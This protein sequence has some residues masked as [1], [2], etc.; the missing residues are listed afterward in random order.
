MTPASGGV[1]QAVTADDSPDQLYDL[2]PC[3]FLT[4]APDGTIIKANA[5][6]LE[7]VGCCA[8][9][10]VGCKRFPELLTRGG[11]IYYETHYAPLLAMHGHVREI[12]LELTRPNAAALPV[13]INAVL[14]RD[15]EGKPTVLRAVVFDASQRRQYERE[16]LEQS[17]RL[18][19]S[20]ARARSLAQT[21]QQTL[22]PPLPPSIPGLDVGACYRP[23]GD[24]TEVGGDFY[25]I[26]QTSDESWVV[27]LGDVCGKGVEAAIL[28]AL[29]RYTLRAAAMQGTRPSD[30]LVVLNEVLHKHESERFATAVCVRLHDEG[31]RWLTK[32][33]HGGHPLILHRASDGTVTTVGSPGDVLG[34]FPGV[35][36]VDQTL[37]LG[38]GEALL[39]YTDGVP[40]A[41]AGS[42]LY[43]EARISEI[44]A[45]PFMTAQE[46]IDE[47]LADVLD[48]QGGLTSDDVACVLIHRPA[49]S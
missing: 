13:L 40:E 23:A 36:I 21:L 24:G 35:E 48:F 29:S 4:L 2:A 18:A 12:A 34:L 49:N 17:Q 47:L 9:D 42:D 15:A 45:R 22:I 32:V 11:Q 20:E 30:A 7:M 37:V 39:A 44:F 6:F 14:E 31:G 5:T 41:R 43:G 25:D 16:L 10:V 1:T 3:G 19:E 26:F 8:E 33:A 27:V 46:R 28:T 38:P